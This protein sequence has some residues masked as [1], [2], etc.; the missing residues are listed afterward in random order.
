MKKKRIIIIAV[1]CVAVVAV[2]GTVFGVRAYNDYTLQQQTEE[3]IK[4]IDDTYA[5]F[6]NETD[7]SKKL[8][9]LSDFIKNKPSTN[10]EIA[11]EV[12]NAVEPKYSETLEKMQEY[13]T[14]DYDKI[15]KDN[16]IISDS[17]NKM[18]DKNKIQDCI[19]KLNSLEEII[20]SEKEIV[21]NQNSQNNADSYL[22]KTDGLISSYSDRIQ[23]IEKSRRAK[24]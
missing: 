3:R 19:D 6:I 15:I 21:L 16:T 9:K 22:K 1:V 14:D 7:R 20:D 17:L 11:V 5:D 2:A 4:S 23:E 12:L 24:S 13:F 18:N 10:D 8:E